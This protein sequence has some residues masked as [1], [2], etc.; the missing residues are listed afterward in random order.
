MSC[1]AIDAGKALGV[2][3]EYQAPNQY[4]APQQ[5]PIINALAAKQPDGLVVSP[6]DDK[7]LIPPLKALADRGIKVSLIDTGLADSSFAVAEVTEDYATGGRKAAAEIARLMGGKGDVVLIAQAPGIT[8]QDNGKAGFE[9]GLEAFPGIKYI[10]TEYDGADPT[11]A[12]SIVAALLA[13][14]PNIRGI[15][16]LNGPSAPGVVN[17]LKRAGKA[18]QVKFLSFDAT[19]QQITALKNGEIDELLFWK[20]YEIGRLGVENVVAALRK[21]PIAEKKILTQPLAVTAETVDDPNLSKF[22][23]KS[24]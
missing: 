21:Q 15:V 2:K 19:P 13:R 24:C 9:Q 14:D 5:I 22:F 17:G 11:K 10:G 8:T 6:T 20:P 1:G 16:T 18:D 23:Y 4:A 7:A 12:S 3:I